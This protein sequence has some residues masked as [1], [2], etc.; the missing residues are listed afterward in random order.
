MEPLELHLQYNHAR[1]KYRE[2]KHEK[3]NL[4]DHEDGDA[5]STR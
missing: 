3:C 2:K 4:T 5:D 1:I